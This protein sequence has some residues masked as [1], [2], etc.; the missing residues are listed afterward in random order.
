MLPML[1]VRKKRWDLEQ[2]N[3]DFFFLYWKTAP[4]PGSYI[5]DFADK[6][7]GSFYRFT[8]FFK[9]VFKYVLFKYSSGFLRSFSEPE[10]KIAVQVAVSISKAARYSISISL[11]YP[12]F[13]VEW[14]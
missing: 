2:V 13:I 8:S 9:A 7:R 12:E 6:I 11:L 5:N 14:S 1:S 3:F 10:N 4:P